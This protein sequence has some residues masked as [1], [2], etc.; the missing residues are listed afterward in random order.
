M[1]AVKT[2]DGM[3]KKIYDL[4]ID[5]ELERVI[6]LLEDAELYRLTESILTEGCRDPLVV[7]DGV[8]VDGHHR[9][10]ICRENNIP[11]TYVEKKF[12]SVMDAKVWIISNQLARRNLN[13]FVRCEIVLPLEESFRI[14]AKKRQGWRK[15]HS[16][17][18][19]KEP[20][21]GK[22]INTREELAN[23]ASVSGTTIRKVKKIV[24]SGDE[25]TINKLRKGKLSINRAYKNI[26][27]QESAKAGNGPS[28]DED[29]DSENDEDDAPG[30]LRLRHFTEETLKPAK[31]R[32]GYGLLVDLP[33]T[34][35]S[36]REIP[37]DSLYDIPPLR[38]CGM[39]PADDL[40]FRGKAEMIHAKSSL[41]REM[42]NH[43]HRIGQILRP[44]TAASINDENIAILRGIIT[45]GYNQTMD[46]LN[47]V[48]ATGAGDAIRTDNNTKEFED[49]RRGW[50]V[51]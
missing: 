27:K 19:A 46:F 29:D 1:D 21:G 44:M 35:D 6:P 2:M 15:G 25:E 26:M 10:N 22:P 8:I 12:E 41:T 16:D 45:Q 49:W 5:P 36:A 9:Y 32:P 30:R 37:P 43:V 33:P 11:F 24:V 51:P 17:L 42:E 31:P 47:L 4:K 39:A 38:T 7:W 40:E 50:I 34:S 18:V 23:M 48:R 14:E 13:E 20:K 28:E 3:E